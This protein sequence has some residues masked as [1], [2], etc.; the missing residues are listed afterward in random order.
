M[1][2]DYNELDMFGLTE[3]HAMVIKELSFSQDL[4]TLIEEANPDN[5]EEFET[6]FKKHVL[7]NFPNVFE[8]IVWELEVKN[9]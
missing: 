7:E 6:Q 3:K 1:D 2:L 8:D 5:P 9:D 4:L